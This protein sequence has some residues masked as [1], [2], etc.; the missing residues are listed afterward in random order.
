MEILLNLAFLST[1]SMSPTARPI[2][3]SCVAAVKE[4]C[5][6]SHCFEHC[7]FYVITLW[8][9]RVSHLLYF[10]LLLL[11]TKQAKR[12]H[13]ESRTLYTS[14]NIQVEGPTANCAEVL[15]NPH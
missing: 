6:V 2:C 5:Y 7:D 1:A 11:N 15:L 13:S 3:Q 4:G 12:L 14:T 10:L 8:S 9:L